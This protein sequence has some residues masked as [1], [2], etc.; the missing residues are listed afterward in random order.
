MPLVSS[1]RPVFRRGIA[2]TIATRIGS[3]SMTPPIPGTAVVHLFKAP[4]VVNP[5]TPYASFHDNEADFTDYSSSGWVSPLGPINAGPNTQG[6]YSTA[7]WLMS[8]DPTVVSN[9]IYGYYVAT[10]ADDNWYLAEAFDSPIPM[11]S[12]GDF[13]DLLIIM[14]VSCVPSISF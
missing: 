9:N 6:I 14:G 2:N 13:L 3:G 10:G 5:D 8:A 7:S 11:D 12:P 4:V 1:K